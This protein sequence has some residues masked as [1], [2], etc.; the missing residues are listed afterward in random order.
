MYIGTFS[1]PTI[2]HRSIICELL[3]QFDQVFIGIG[4]DPQKDP[5]FSNS[6]RINLFELTMADLKWEYK[7]RFLTHQKFSIAEEITAKKLEKDS[8]VFQA[9]NYDDMTVDFAL[10]NK[11]NILARGERIVGDHDA[12]MELAMMNKVLGRVRGAH[13]LQMQICTPQECLTYISSSKA[14][15]FC[16]KSEYIAAQDFVSPAVHTT[17][18]Q[19]YLKADFLALAKK[20]GCDSDDIAQACWYELSISCLHYYQGLSH[21]GY[22]LNR[23]KDYRAAGNDVEYYDELKAAIYYS[24]FD[25]D[26]VRKSTASCL[27]IMEKSSKK[28]RDLVSRLIRLLSEYGKEPKSFEDKLFSDIYYSILGDPYHYGRYYAL[29]QRR[30]TVF[31]DEPHGQSRKEEIQKLLSR[32]NIYTLPFFIDKYAEN[33]VDNLKQELF[34]WQNYI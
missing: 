31:A 7:Y 16:Q 13:L 1:P 17:M 4:K 6:E 3:A 10:R 24:F 33:A 12:E 8:N 22:C 30:D 27:E 5:L 23:L 15:G 20:L 18:M 19:K 2:G 32:N 11:I 26:N 21:I 28:S 14:H 34:Y 29:A 9:L 25:R